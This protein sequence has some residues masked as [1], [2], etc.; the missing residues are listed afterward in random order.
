MYFLKFSTPMQNLEFHIHQSHM[1]IEP[2]EA[3][4]FCT[5]KMIKKKHFMS[6]CKMINFFQHVMTNFST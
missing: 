3:I 1:E 5:R 2:S 4:K 6:P